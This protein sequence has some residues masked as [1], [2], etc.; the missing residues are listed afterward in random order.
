M[1]LALKV[2]VTT[3]RGA[4]DGVP[5]LASL[6]QQHGAGATFFFCVGGGGSRMAGL[7]SSPGLGRRAGGAMR[8]IRDAGFDTGVQAADA[9]H[10]CRHVAHATAAWTQA[11]MQLAID[12][13]ADVF[14]EA[15]RSHAAAGWQTNAQALRLTQRLGFDFCSDGRGHGPHLPVRNAELVRCPQLPTTLPTLDEFLGEAGAGAGRAVTRIL[16]QTA[17]SL[18]DS[19]VFTLCADRDGRG[20]LQ[21]VEDLIKGWLGLGL[22]LVALRSLYEDLEPLQL[23]RCIVT[24]DPGHG[25]RF[26]M[27]GAEFLD[28]CATIGLDTSEADIDEGES[29][30]R[31]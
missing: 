17:T 28:D 29:H 27:Q 26:L 3:L 10:W 24:L 13:Y 20:R 31:C 15:P 25:S 16:E 14:G 30:V 1:K 18:P 11:Q 23:P 5:R 6:F 4:R 8:A 7:L 12:R 21:D 2:D 22:E 9:Q 19:A